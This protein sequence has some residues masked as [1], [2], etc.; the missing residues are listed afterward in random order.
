MLPATQTTA[1]QSAR[2]A[3]RT[4]QI[5]ARTDA[6]VS[7]R[8]VP[9]AYLQHPAREELPHIDKHSAAI[10]LDR[11]LFRMARR[12]SLCR[13]RLGRLAARLL[14]TRSYHRLGFARIGDYTLERLGLSARELQSAARVWRRTA[15]V[16]ALAHAFRTGTL[17]WT[18]LRTL[19]ELPDD[20]DMSHWIALAASINSRELEA[21]VAAHKRAAARAATTDQAGAGAGADASAGILTGI[22]AGAAADTATSPTDDDDNDLLDGEP[23]VEV[24]VRCPAHLRPLWNDVRELAS[25]SA[26]SELAPWQALELV[27]AEA[28]SG[29]ALGAPS[30][31]SPLNDE[32][33]TDT[34][35]QARWLGITARTPSQNSDDSDNDDDPSHTPHRDDVLYDH[36]GEAIDPADVLMLRA[37]LA[38]ND[39]LELGALDGSPDEH[40][41]DSDR[42]DL[43]SLDADDLDNALRDVLT[44]MRSI[45]W[46][47]G[48]L[49]STFARLSL[50]RQVGYA[51]TASYVR[52]RLGISSRKARSLIRLE[53]N[54]ADGRDELA[55]A[56]RRGDLSWVRA[57]ALLPVMS[58]R[59]AA[60]WI[61]RARCVTIRRLFDEVR[62]ALDMRD[63]AW[64]FM[65]LVP[66]PLGTRLQHSNEEAERQMRALYGDEMAARIAKQAPDDTTFVRLAGPASVIDLF[67]DVLQA[68][69]DPAVPWEPAW[70]A[71]ERVLLHAKAQWSDV[72]RHRNPIHDRDGWRCR[73]PACSSRRNLQEHHVLYRS[74]GGGNERG[75]RI[76]ICAWHHLRGIHTGRVRATGDAEQKIRWQL[77]TNLRFIDDTYAAPTGFRELWEL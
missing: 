35:L 11:Y 76:S 20:V 40:A 77:G 53:A 1:P 9:S 6:P 70:R 31:P 30:I 27:C 13:L 39:A 72:P 74:R 15:Q 45:D 3:A 26:G 29:A 71:L 69:R 58:E 68:F 33:A 18:K 50:H 65:E 46:Q 49:L 21:H 14:D 25:R 43:T 12:E 73:V 48:R 24:R 51:S 42:R 19:C 67:Y 52:E 10:V 60:A 5:R 64:M 55:D 62:W 56:Y 8:D 17:N 28:S 32:A 7:T 75:N 61:E 23:R 34:A 41:N 16:P 22:L 54:P 66:P 57:L 59:H 38:D 37:L 47:L 36:V 63:R 44:A 2:P 4:P